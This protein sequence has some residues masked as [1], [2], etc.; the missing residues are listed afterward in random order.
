[1]ADRYW[2]GG[3]GNWTDMA[4]WSASSG[5]A[6]GA[7]VPTSADNA[8]FDANS[9]PT[10]YTVT[11]NGVTNDCRDLNF[12]AAPSVSG[13]ITWSGSQPMRVYGS[14]TY[15]AGMIATFNGSLRFEATS[16]G[17]TIN[18]N[19]VIHNG[20]VRPDFIGVGEWT[21]TGD[22]QIN[23]SASVGRTTA[24]NTINWNGFA[25]IFS[26]N[27]TPGISGSDLLLDELQLIG[28]TRLSFLSDQTIGVLSSVGTSNARVTVK[29]NLRGVLR[30]LTV[31]AG[32]FEYTDFEDIAIV[33]AAAPISGVELG[34]GQ[35][36]S[37][38]T[39]D[40]PKTRYWVATSGGSWS[41][42][43]SW[44]A[45]SGGAS[46]ATVPLI[47]DTV[48]FDA[49]S[50]TSTGRTISVNA[51][52]IGKD[53][54][55]SGILHSPTF[56]TALFIPH[57]I[58]G[59]ITLG[60][61]L[62][63][64]QIGFRIAGQGGV[65]ID[66]AGVGLSGHPG[67]TI[68]CNPGTVT[69]GSDFSST[70][71]AAGID[72]L[73]GTF[74]TNDFNMSIRRLTMNGT[75]TRALNLRSSFVTLLDIAIGNTD[76]WSIAGSNYTFTP[77]TSTIKITDTSKSDK[78]MT[79]SGVTYNNVW[80]ACAPT[81]IRINNTSTYNQ[82]RVDPGATVIFG[83][84]SV[85]TAADWQ[86]SGDSPAADDYIGMRLPRTS[87]AYA[88]VTRNAALATLT[89]DLTLIA[90][91]RSTDYTGV[92]S[93]CIVAKS[94][95]SAQ[96]DFRWTISSSSRLIFQFRD[97]GGTLR[98]LIL[99][100]WNEPANFEDIWLKVEF[101][102]DNGAGNAV[103]T[104]Y[105]SPD[106]S[107]WTNEG[108]ANLAGAPYTMQDKAASVIVVGSDI[109]S[110]S[111][112]I[113]FSGV[114]YKAQVYNGIGGG[115]TLVE[116]F[117]PADDF[118]SGTTFMS[119]VTSET[120]TTSAAA[121]I[122]QDN[123]TGMSH[124][125]T[126]VQ[127]ATVAKSGGGSVRAEYLALRRND[128]P[129]NYVFAYHGLDNGGVTD[130]GS[131]KDSIAD[132]DGVSSVAALGFSVRSAAAVAAGLATVAAVGR[133]LRSAVA[134]VVGAATSSA[135]ARII[136]NVIAS[137]AGVATALAVYFR[138]PTARVLDVS[139]EERTLTVRERGRNG[140]S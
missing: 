31:A 69:L 139:A 127:Q 135:V 1:M 80:V 47:H 94:D 6:S 99:A 78:I 7:S 50:I 37:G 20:P 98:D 112:S 107:A 118:V 96:C 45:T 129:A 64:A 116:E 38:I 95:N 137:C 9:N 63:A 108:F 53:L 130:W 51:S 124:N 106:G 48:V 115:A 67:I 136:W 121:L 34:D 72:I 22:W 104:F 35:G 56:A 126:A 8:I 88:A 23:G 24:A 12:S 59:S 128:A 71:S 110:S 90:H 55:M 66:L 70:G 83:V 32:S 132:S 28:P 13:T 119:G 105:S 140:L 103:A 120:W 58:Y 49:N 77:G 15:L 2:V 10:A 43:N 84:G 133:S 29:S 36:N 42:L 16:A 122:A 92:N 65:S 86:I 61:G 93:Q 21:F 109:N 114:I 33:G 91:I 46:G 73:S 76:V 138:T 14:L 82:L 18:P 5:G 113:P 3:S 74:D 131:L 17:H 81:S 57:D 4:H 100:S 102:A 54:D 30:T 89:G 11:I 39:F 27:S 62:G 79:G 52:K 97:S 40:A 19:G 26:G 85:H 44:S 75:F 123:M 60:P 41:N 25:L 68:D 101:D 87:D 117:N 134:S 125:G 111:T